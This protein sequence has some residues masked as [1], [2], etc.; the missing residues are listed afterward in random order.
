MSVAVFFGLVTRC[1]GNLAIL[2]GGLAVLLCSSVVGTDI[3][4]AVRG[5]LVVNVGYALMGAS[6]MLV[7]SS[8]RP[9]RLLCALAG[10]LGMLCGPFDVVY[11]DRAPGFEVAPAPNKFL[12][13]VGGALP[14]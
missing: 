10:L 14:H 6:G 12:R 5:C 7:A 2:I 13:S 3:T 9:V 4:N 1:P 11:S 8:R